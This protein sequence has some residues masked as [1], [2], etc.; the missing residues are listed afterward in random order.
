MLTEDERGFLAHALKG[1][2][3]A[4]E[5]CT[6]LGFVSQVWDDLKDGDHVTDDDLNTAF[7]QMLFALPNNVFYREHFVTLQALMQAAV[8]DWYAANH[9]EEGSEQDCRVAYVLRDSLTR[10]VTMCAYL[11]G[12]PDWGKRISVEVCTRLYDES[13]EDY[14]KEHSHG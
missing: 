2:E 9:M 7:R 10:I 14:V 5:F 12:G 3:D 8:F 6:S 13:M 1:N 11:V 4:I